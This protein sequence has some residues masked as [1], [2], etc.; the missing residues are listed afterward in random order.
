MIYIQPI[1]K[2]CH[3]CFITCSQDCYQESTIDI[4][5]LNKISLVSWYGLL[6]MQVFLEKFGFFCMIH[7]KHFP[8]TF[9]YLKVI[10]SSQKQWWFSEI[11]F[12]IKPIIPHLN[13]ESIP[14]SPNWFQNL[15]EVE[16]CVNVNIL[17][18][19][20]HYI[21]FKMLLLGKMGSVYWISLFI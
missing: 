17:A 1:L 13:Y 15:A 19:L 9:Y 11:F 21:F 20:F 10:I 18:I 3:N 14:L 12:F 7:H 5:T 4:H 2:C 6:C 16:D 8:Y